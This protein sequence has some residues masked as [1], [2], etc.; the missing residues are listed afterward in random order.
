SLCWN[1][2][3]FWGPRHLKGFPLAD[4]GTFGEKGIPSGSQSLKQHAS[5]DR[6]LQFRLGRSPQL[7]AEALQLNVHS[8]ST[9][10]GSSQRR[11]PP[12]LLWFQLHAGGLSVVLQRVCSMHRLQSLPPRRRLPS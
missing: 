1:D 12:A 3:V 10:V 6:H 5:Q 2:G 11:P 7:H 8:F 4:C 9:S